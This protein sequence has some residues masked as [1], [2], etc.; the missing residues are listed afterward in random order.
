MK[1]ISILA[2][3]DTTTGKLI[4]YTKKTVRRLSD[5]KDFYYDK[6]SVKE[7]L[8][9]SNPIIYE[10]YAYETRKEPG[11]LSFA[12]TILYP[13]KIGKEFYMTK[14]HFHMKRDR[15][16]I[17]LGIAGSGLMLIMNE[18]GETS[19]IE[20]KPNTIIYVPPNHAHRAVNTGKE[21]LIFLAIYPSDAGHDYE[22]IIERGFS[23]III[24]DNGEIRVIDNPKFRK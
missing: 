18:D 1:E 11:N 3:I 23:K 8:S 12:T 14:G 15:S 10:V 21:R 24:E 6:E 13:G 7:I 4:N 16:E 17:Y 5:M 22:A 20:I 9:R 2:K 19:I